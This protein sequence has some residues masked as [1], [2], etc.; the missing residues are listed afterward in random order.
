MTKIDEFLILYEN[1]KRENMI[2]YVKDE[3]TRFYN[4]YTEYDKFDLFFCTSS[5]N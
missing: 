4:Y 2:Q 5:L 3:I 1:Q